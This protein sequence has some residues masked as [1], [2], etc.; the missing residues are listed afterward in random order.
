[1]FR[2]EIWDV[3]ARKICG[4]VAHDP[5]FSPLDFYH[6]IFIRISLCSHVS[7]YEQPSAR[8]NRDC[9]ISLT[10]LTIGKCARALM[11]IWWTEIHQ[12]KVRK[13]ARFHLTRI[14]TPRVLK[15]R[16]T[17]NI[18]PHRRKFWKTC[19]KKE[20]GPEAF[21][22]PP[23]ITHLG[24]LYPWAHHF[25]ARRLTRHV[26]ATQASAWTRVALPRVCRAPHVCATQVSAWGSR[27]SATCPT[28]RH[29]SPQFLGKIPLFLP[30]F[31]GIKI[32]KNQNKFQ[33]N[34][35][36]SEINIFKNTT[37]L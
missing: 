3:R 1:M 5:G 13:F 29:V 33:K 36:N 25:P 6:P 27:G 7:T 11:A 14:V 31:K 8:F 9:R 30:F 18:V 22:L 20:E 37:P 34:P 10:Q 23:Q 32:R 19:V 24:Q 28:P 16:N 26:G 17:G 4:F 2:D 12:I 15:L 35:K 21:A